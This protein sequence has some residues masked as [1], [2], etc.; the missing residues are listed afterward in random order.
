[1]ASIFALER[2]Y[3]LV[4]PRIEASFSTTAGDPPVTTAHVPCDWGKTRPPVQINAGSVGRVVFVPGNVDGSMGSLNGA[5]QWAQPAKPLY[6]MQMP[7]CVYVWGRGTTN[8]QDDPT[9]DHAA[10]RVLHEVIRQIRRVSW[11]ISLETSPVTIGEPKILK[12]R[13]QHGLG[14]EYL[15]PCSIEQPILDMLD[16]TAGWL[17]VAPAE[18]EIT[19]TLGNYSDTAHVTPED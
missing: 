17:D 3:S 16:D 14:V 10:F 9:H 8:K 12:P 1:M 5:K 15:L 6:C 18:A 19:E 2:L 7:F 4:K 11:D 13:A